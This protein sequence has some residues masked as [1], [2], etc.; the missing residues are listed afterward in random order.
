MKKPTLL[1]L[2]GWNW[3]NYSKFG[4]TDSWNNRTEFIN[5]LEKIFDVHKVIFPGFCGVAEPSAP[6]TLDD[7][8]EYVK[9]YL[10]DN[11]LHPDFVLGYSFG[12]AVAIR[13]KSHFGLNCPII[14]VSP[15]IIRATSHSNVYLP[16]SWKKIIP[17]FLVNFVREIYLSYIVNNPYYKYG[18][19][20]LKKTYLDIVCVDLSDELSL[21]SMGDFVCIFG[22]DDTATP[23]NLLLKKISNGNV[24]KMIKIIDSGRHD[25]AN[26]H[27][28]ELVNL[29]RNFVIEKGGM[30]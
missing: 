1:L 10:E 29:I 9:K 2:H 13:L 3:R 15:A 11:N 6:W 21:L 16:D 22:S 19:K 30:K 25:I 24:I 17:E 7:F 20:F 12:G 8:A 26:T 4:N 5:E 28:K 23:S 18:T 14:L 27:T